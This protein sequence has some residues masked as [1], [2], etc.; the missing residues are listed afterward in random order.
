[1]KRYIMLITV[2]LTMLSA[3]NARPVETKFDTL[4]WVEREFITVIG[5][6]PHPEADGD[7][8]HC[9]CHAITSCYLVSFLFGFGIV[10]V[11]GAACMAMSGV[12]YLYVTLRLD[13]VRNDLEIKYWN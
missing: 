5:Y 9:I 12:M 1:M 4:S 6:E 11:I 2:L 3:V 7:E 8:M 13:K 10:G